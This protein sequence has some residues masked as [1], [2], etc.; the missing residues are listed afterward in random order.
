MST[1]GFPY[2]TP[3][4]TVGGALD[5]HSAPGDSWFWAGPTRGPK[6]VDRGTWKGGSSWGRGWGRK[7]GMGEC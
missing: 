4:P 5:V 6:G 1:V 2:P 7:G 3:P